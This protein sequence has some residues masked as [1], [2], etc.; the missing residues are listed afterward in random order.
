M[1]TVGV[2]GLINV[3]PLTFAGARLQPSQPNGLISVWFVFDSNGNRVQYAEPKKKVN[4][5]RLRPSRC[6]LSRAVRS[7]GNC[8]SLPTGERS[9]PSVLLSAV[10]NCHCVSCVRCVTF[11][12]KTARNSPFK[13]HS[14]DSG[15]VPD[16]VG[17]EV[18]PELIPK[19][20]TPLLDLP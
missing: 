2:K 13:S 5:H 12:P 16:V 8:L 20:S 3:D 10:V 14:D 19:S 4:R 17:K 6:L 7:V 1:S 15:P 11:S 18:L 9:A